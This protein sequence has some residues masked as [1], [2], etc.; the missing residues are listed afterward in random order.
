MA[1]RTE[2]QKLTY[3]DHFAKKWRCDG[4]KSV[5]GFPISRKLQIRNIE[6]CRRKK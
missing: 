5:F 2:E 6:K 3:Y 4:K 1:S